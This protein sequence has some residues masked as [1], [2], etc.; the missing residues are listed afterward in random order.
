MGNPSLVK[1]AE[2]NK[3]IVIRDSFLD[4]FL[5]ADIDGQGVNEHTIPMRLDALLIFLVLEGSSEIALDYTPYTI[6]ANRFVIIMPTHTMQVYKM[7]KDFRGKLLIASKEFLDECNTGNRNP[8]MANYMQLRKN[9]C[10]VLEP[11]ETALVDNNIE[12]LRLKINNH[13]HFFYKE[14]ILNAFMGFLLEI[15]NLFMKKRGGMMSST[16]SRREE[17]FEQFLQLLFKHCKEQHVVSF[18]AERLCITPQYLS[19]ILKD[20]SGKSAN[21]WIDEALI[22]EAKILLRAPQATVQQVADVLHFSDQSTFGKFFKK[23]MGIS[24]MEYRKS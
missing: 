8:S 21:K 5:V 22:V 23:H 6:E 13:D 10:T 19:L 14:M 16:L 15:G 18:Y 2:L 4:L 3:G 20:L 7:S 12:L 11:E 9:P 24:P 17:I 1:F